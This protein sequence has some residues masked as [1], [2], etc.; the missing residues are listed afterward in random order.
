MRII[1]DPSDIPNWFNLSNY[2]GLKDLSDEEAFEQLEFRYALLLV[3]E[4]QSSS[5]NEESQ[6]ED[7]IFES[8]E[9]YRWRS[10]VRGGPIINFQ[11]DYRTPQ[12]IDDD[13]H[14]AEWLSKI[15][16]DAEVN[17]KVYLKAHPQQQAYWSEWDK[18]MDCARLNRRA[19]TANNAIKGIQVSQLSY[20]YNEFVEN[21]LI[22]KQHILGGIAGSAHY[23]D[24]SCAAIMNGINIYGNTGAYIDIDLA[25]ATDDEIVRQIKL[26]LP[27]WRKTLNVPPPN[28]SKPTPTLFS[29]IVPYRIIPYLDLVIW[30]SLYDYHITHELF[31]NTLF[32]D[33]ERDRDNFK[34]VVL[35]HE[36]KLR[37]YSDNKFEFMEYGGE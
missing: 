26:F 3:L 20:I 12:E 4:T 11:K 35:A 6:T 36:K 37:K 22:G 10:I 27:K 25:M 21:G 18:E 19:L 13:N 28:S 2:L 5:L 29:K 30:S 17:N 24:I 34:Q 1:S 14:A 9:H 15:Q 23:S 33:K 31:S 32:P 16:N 8:P 7:N